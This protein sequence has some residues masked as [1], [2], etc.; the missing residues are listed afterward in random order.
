MKS[1]YLLIRIGIQIHLLRPGEIL[2]APLNSIRVCP[3]IMP[4]FPFSWGKG[5][6]FKVNF[7]VY[8]LDFES[9]DDL[10]PLSKIRLG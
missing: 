1:F 6:Y 7:A 8:Y 4:Y 3:V 10:V 5:W 9:N 2:H